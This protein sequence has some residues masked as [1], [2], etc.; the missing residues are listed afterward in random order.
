MLLAKRVPPV[1]VPPGA[2]VSTTD[3]QVVA[4]QQEDGP[5]PGRAQAEQGREV[6]CGLNAQ[7]RYTVHMPCTTRH[8]PRP[9]AGT[10]THQTHNLL[11]HQPCATGPLAR[12]AQTPYAAKRWICGVGVWPHHHQG[13]PAPALPA[14]VP[15]TAPRSLPSRPPLT[16]HCHHTYCSPLGPG[17][18]ARTWGGGKVCME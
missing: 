1:G 11:P 9:R 13:R 2:A 4:T 10:F 12:P 15:L 3:M 16:V 17:V 6:C 14:P 7:Q 8:V 5:C 18:E